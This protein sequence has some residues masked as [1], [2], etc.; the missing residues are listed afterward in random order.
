MACYIFEC[1][2]SP[3]KH[4][5]R[6]GTPDRVETFVETIVETIVEI[7]VETIQH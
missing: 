2:N 5:V 4:A 3:H 1:Y 7:I 6:G